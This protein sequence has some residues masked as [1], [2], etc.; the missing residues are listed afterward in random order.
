MKS[1]KGQGSLEYLFMVAAALV[2][3]LVI[4]KVLSGISGN[5]PEQ[6]V[7]LHADP[8]DFPSFNI[9]DSYFVYQSVVEKSGD[10]YVITYRATAKRDLTNV[11]IRATLKCNKKP[12]W[13]GDQYLT[14]T[15]EVETLPKGWY[16]S[17]SWSPVRSDEF[18][19]EVVL[20]V[21][22]G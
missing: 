6:Q 11:K 12:V 21:W 8:E 14:I 19:C 20:Y 3:I 18:P 16:I 2:I 5:I 15:D 7:I 4:I 17:E 1:Y 22:V 13:I 9:S 10:N